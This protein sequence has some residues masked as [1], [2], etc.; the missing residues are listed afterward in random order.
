[1]AYPESGVA[2]EGGGCPGYQHIIL[3]SLHGDGYRRFDTPI[4]KQRY[5]NDVRGLSLG[6]TGVFLYVQSFDNVERL[7]IRGRTDYRRLG[8]ARAGAFS[9]LRVQGRR[10]SW[11]RN[12]RRHSIRFRI[13]PEPL[14]R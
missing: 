6:A 5:A 2:C 14:R 3:I 13:V 4:D 10:A 1:V 12:T 7:F 9:H 8:R 11:K